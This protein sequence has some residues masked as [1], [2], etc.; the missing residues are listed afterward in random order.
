MLVVTALLICCGNFVES[1]LSPSRVPSKNKANEV[2]FKISQN[3]SVC[4][5][6]HLPRNAKSSVNNPTAC[7]FKKKNADNDDTKLS[8]I[9]RLKK[10]PGTLLILPFVALVGLDLLLNIAFLTK[11]TIEYFALGQLPST[12]TWY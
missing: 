10:R 12:E 2:A 9:G 7:E 3:Q 6:F 1:F 11:R 4:A 8:T 5:R